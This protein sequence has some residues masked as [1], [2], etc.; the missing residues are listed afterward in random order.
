MDDPDDIFISKRLGSVGASNETI[1]INNTDTL[2]RT[3]SKKSGLNFIQSVD[4]QDSSSSR[5]SASRRHSRT[6]SSS[7]HDNLPTN[8][9]TP[10]VLVVDVVLIFVVLNVTLD[11]FYSQKYLIT[12]SNEE[13]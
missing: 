8:E 2:N 5:I 3:Y 13:K 11:V 10:L 4:S 1:N 6:I 7:I 12:C 9:G